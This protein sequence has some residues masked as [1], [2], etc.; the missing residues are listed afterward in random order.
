MCKRTTAT[1]GSSCGLSTVAV[2]LLCHLSLF[3]ALA[4][5]DLTE[6]AKKMERKSLMGFGSAKLRVLYT[7][8]RLNT[9][10]CS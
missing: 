3:R 4:K 8:T 5:V 9:Q 6:K 10:P 7:Q 1:G 2:T